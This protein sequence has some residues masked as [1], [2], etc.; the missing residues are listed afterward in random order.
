MTNTS[1]SALAIVLA[2]AGCGS[3]GPA[4][5][6]G[7]PAPG[8]MPPAGT[9]AAIAFSDLDPRQGQVSGTITVS[10]AAD[11]SDVTGYAVYW[12]T[13]A[14]DR[15]GLAPIVV[16]AKTGAQV[17]YPLRTGTTVPPGATYL[18][19]FAANDDGDAATPAATAIAD[20]Y[21]AVVDL[22]MGMPAGTYALPT[23]PVIDTTNDKLFFLT[24]MRLTTARDSVLFHCA[25]DGTQCTAQDLGV[26]GFDQVAIDAASAV[27]VL[28][29]SSTSG[30]SG[31]FCGLAGT[32]CVTRNLASGT[33]AAGGQTVGA[34]IFD[35]VNHKLLV[36]AGRTGGLGVLRTAPDGTAPSYTNIFPVDAQIDYYDAQLIIDAANAKL[37]VISAALSVG[38]GASAIIISRCNLDVTGCQVV[39]TALPTDYFDHAAYEASRQHVAIAGF[40][41]ATGEWFLSDCDS[42]FATCATLQ[43]QDGHPWTPL[44]PTFDATNGML[45]MLAQDTITGVYSLQRCG[46]TGY[47]CQQIDLPQVFGYDFAIDDMGGRLVMP[48][49][50]VPTEKLSAFSLRTW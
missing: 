41:S 11:E 21:P 46:A 17:S 48:Y 31:I 5:P 40:Y 23:G 20:N 10:P 44:H 1:S 13:S 4:G 18:L 24:Y 28:T 50:D 2:V 29:G 3:T 49:L 34:A 27:L 6:Q 7:P 38:S 37:I 39:T 9:P 30:T 42:A 43:P 36:V 45:Y 26:T 25:A 12:G 33:A 15:A 14:T 16:V 35:D 47:P 32:G 8:P 22:S 19:A